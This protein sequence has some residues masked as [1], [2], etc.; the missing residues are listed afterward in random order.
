[1]PQHTFSI[2]P[3]QAAGLTAQFLLYQLG[4]FV[5]IGLI[6][7]AYGAIAHLSRPTGATADPVVLIA[8]NSIAVVLVLRGQLRKSKIPWRAMSDW[9]FQSLPILPVFLLLMG[10]E[11]ITASEIGNRV[12]ALLPPPQWLR[13]YALPL[14]DL[15]SHPVSA[16]F[17]LVV[18]AAVTEEVLF[19]GMILRGLLARMEPVR[20]VGISA[21]LFAVMHLNPWQMPSAFLIGSILG[22]VYLHTRSLALCIVGHGFH[23]AMCL[24]A[25]GLPF[26]IDGFNTMPSP[27]QAL[28]QPWWLNLLGFGLLVAGGWLLHRQ[29]PRFPWP[30]EQPAE[31]P[32][33]PVNSI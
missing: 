25:T 11:V 1:V 33:L 29:A 8:V 3:K 9:G 19:R 32:L 5:A 2:S 10:G 20:A 17:A 12:S 26:T 23:N 6:A 30:R 27:G 21:G 28:F 18:M 31:P 22:W 24:L 16:P 14:F 15:A 4:L 13:D 7:G